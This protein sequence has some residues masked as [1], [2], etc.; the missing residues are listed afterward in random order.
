[1]FRP[2]KCSAEIVFGRK[3][4]GRKVFR[5][6]IFSAENVFGRTF[7]RPKKFSAENFLVE[8]L[9]G[10]KKFRLKKKSVENSFGRKLFGRKTFR[11]KISPSVS[12]FPSATPLYLINFAQPSGSQTRTAEEKD[13]K[14]Q[15]QPTF[16]QGQ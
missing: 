8:N 7:F 14:T 4:F 10:R 15:N 9:F 12:N 13:A 16:G 2:K 6:K 11:R 3:F 1:M 5:S